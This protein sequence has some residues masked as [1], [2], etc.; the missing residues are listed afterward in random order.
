MALVR[1]AEGQ[2]RSGSIGGSV[3]SHNRAGAYIRARSVPVNPNTNRQ[4]EVRNYVRSLAIAWQ[5]TLT[6][7]QRDSWNMYGAAIAWQNALGD[8]ITLTGLNHYIRSNVPR[9]LCGLARID[10]GPAFFE[11][12]TAE[13]A[14]GA[15]ASEATQQVTVTFDD[16]ADWCSED[17]SV[18]VIYMGRPQDSGIGFFNGPWR[19]LLCIEGDS[20]APPA[21]PA[22]AT[23]VP[24]WPIAA[25]QKIWL[26]S[27]IGRADG[28]LSQ[29][30]Q[31]TF[32][33]A[34]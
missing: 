12:A 34:V 5:M 6:P 10:D 14:L 16:T 21:S 33:A 32:L 13:L 8:L 24:D 11:L 9:L 7:A 1:W 25:G 15:T 30:A 20:V 17:E 4:V 31:T 22:P 29:F 3:Y 26:R 18:Q 19:R 28:R 27:R 23:L 2:Q